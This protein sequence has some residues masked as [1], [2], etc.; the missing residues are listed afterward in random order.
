M[1]LLSRVLNNRFSAYGTR[2]QC[3][4]FFLHADWAP[5][6]LAPPPPGRALKSGQ[7][8]LSSAVYWRHLN[9]NQTITKTL[10]K[11]I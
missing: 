5:T 8:P 6:A 4:I 11:S 2:R 9:K 1:D 7:K 10:F 3:I